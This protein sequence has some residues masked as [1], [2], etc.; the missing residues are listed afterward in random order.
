VAWPGWDDVRWAGT[1][2]TRTA[3]NTPAAFAG[4]CSTARGVEP[5]HRLA[6]VEAWNEWGE[7][8]VIE[9]GVG[10][11]FGYL[12]AIRD[13]LALAPRGTLRRS[14]PGW[15]PRS[16]AANK[17]DARYLADLY[18]RPMRARWGWSTAS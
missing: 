11:G 6:L 10:E 4:C 17:G 15:R 7:G 2:A 8:S 18:H 1:R 5:T 16:P 12:S 9:P 14:R 3:G 13:A